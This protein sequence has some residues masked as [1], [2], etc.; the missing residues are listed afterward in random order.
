MPISFDLIES[1]AL[2]G[3]AGD[4]ST[5]VT[6][7]RKGPADQRENPAGIMYIEKPTMLLC[8]GC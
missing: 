1:A 7:Q 6:V 4:H 2:G 5:S 3:G 8:P